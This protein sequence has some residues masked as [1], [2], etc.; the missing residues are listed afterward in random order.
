MFCLLQVKMRAAYIVIHL[1]F[2]TSNLV[3]NGDGPTA[4][5]RMR[6]AYK[7]TELILDISPTTLI[8]KKYTVANSIC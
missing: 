3:D 5:P 1:N 8:H 2:D 6:L 4:S 7:V